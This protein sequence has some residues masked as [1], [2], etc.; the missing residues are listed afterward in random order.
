MKLHNCINRARYALY[1]GAAALLVP[2]LSMAEG[3]TSNTTGP[4]TTSGADW[5]TTY[6]V[7]TLTSVNS[8]ADGLRTMFGN[9]LGALVPVLGAVI[10]A[11]VAV[12]AM[13]KIVGIIKSAFQTSK[14]R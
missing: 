6:S 12:W 14:G 10:L 3:E 8:A 1:T 4:I 7:G 11:G 5:S 2:A 13:P 9:I